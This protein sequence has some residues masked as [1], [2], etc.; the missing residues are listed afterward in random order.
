MALAGRVHKAISDFLCN[1]SC[2]ALLIKVSDDLQPL[3]AITPEKHLE[4]DLMASLSLLDGYITPRSPLYVIIREQG[5]LVFITYVPF[6]AP[7]DQ[8]KLI[9][10]ERLAVAAE[11]GAENLLYACICKEPADILDWRAWES[12]EASLSKFESPEHMD[13]GENRV[14]H[15]TQGMP[16]F[17]DLGYTKHHC[18][19]CDRRLTMPITDE[20]KA[21]LTNLM[22]RGSTFVDV[23]TETITLG[24]SEIHAL[25][26]ELPSKVSPQPSFTF[27]NHSESGSLIF[28][29]C[30]PP[31]ATVKARMTHTMAVPG[32]VNV[33]AREAGVE[34]TRKIEIDGPEDLTPDLLG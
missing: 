24:L 14:V 34:V 15:A 8:R 4:P 22:S 20:A 2:F 27:Y 19:L 28:I 25:P 5:R 12:R 29:Y 11:L 21:A 30:C 3:P 17:V 18:R 9:M 7:Q 32:L 23:P 13:E 33:I 16:R 6:L 26:S 10:D 31:D 1:E